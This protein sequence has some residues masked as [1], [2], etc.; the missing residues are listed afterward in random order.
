MMRQILAK[1]DTEFTKRGNWKWNRN[2]IPHSHNGRFIDRA[3]IMHFAVGVSAGLMRVK[4]LHWF[5]L[6]TAWEIIEKVF[7]KLT[8]PEIEEPLENSIV[9]TV[10]TMLGQQI[11]LHVEG[12]PTWLNLS[13]LGIS[14]FSI[15]F[16]HSI[17]PSWRPYH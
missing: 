6:H 11:G 2:P 10:F 5:A 12:A 8:I 9:D 14:V 16:V 7:A 4:P 15:V 1:I 17:S 3:T 13:A